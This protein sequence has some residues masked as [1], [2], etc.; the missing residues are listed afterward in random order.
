MADARIVAGVRLP[1]GER[2]ARGGT[3]DAPV[4]RLGRVER[5]RSPAPRHGRARPGGGAAGSVYAAGAAGNAASVGIQ[6][7]LT[8][9]ASFGPD[10][11]ADMAEAFFAALCGTCQRSRGE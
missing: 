8:R 6:R 10:L 5:P 4:A 1:A 2:A 11:S 9:L 7:P 3:H